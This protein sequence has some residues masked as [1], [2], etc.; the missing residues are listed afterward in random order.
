MKKLIYR[1]IISLILI[2]S[3]SII[4]LSTIGLKTERFNDLIVSKI[5]EVDPNLNLKINQVSVKL[6]L[7]SLVINLK[8]LGTDL[9]YKNRIIELEN[10]KSQI[11][12]K[13]VIK[14]RFALSEI[15][16]STKSIPI[17]NLISLIRSIKN[18]PKLLFAEKFIENGYIIAD[19]K[20]E[21]NKLGNIKKNFKINGLV[22]NA[23]LSLTKNKITKLNFIFQ[24]TD[25]E[26]NF[27]DVRLLLNNKSLSIPELRAKKQKNKFFFIGKL[28]NQNLNFKKDEISEIIDNKFLNSNFN[29]ITF[30]SNS[31][32]TFNIDEKFKIKDLDIKSLINVEK[33]EMN[34]FL[35]K[36]SFLP[37][38]KKEII[39]ENQKIKLSYYKN[40]IDIIGSGNLFLQDN[41][42]NINYEI[43]CNK[44][45]YLFNV[46]LKIN[47]NPFT[48]DFINFEKNIKNNLDFKIKGTFKK[49]TLRFDQITLS[50]NENILSVENL[51]L[52]N[53]FKIEEIKNIRL[54][55][56]DKAKQKNDL[57]FKKDKKKYIIIGDS[58]NADKLITD[59][60]KSKKNDKKNFL[61]KNLKLNIDIKKVFLDQNSTVNNLKGNISFV[62][63]EIIE[64]NLDSEFLNKKNMKFTIKKNNDEKITTLFSNEAKPLVDRYKFIKGFSEGVLDFYSVKK[65]N[66]TKSTIKIYD[67]KLKELP[68][69]TKVL[70]LASLQ[71]IADLLSGEGIRF[72]EFEMNFS[73]EKD[74]MTI[75]EI[76]AIGPAISV[77]V[78]GYIEK[79]NLISLRGTLVPATT[80]N[81]TISSIPL[82]GDILVGKKVGEGVFGV[83][84]K[85]KGPPGNLETTVNPIKTLTPRFITRTLEKIKKN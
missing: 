5:R 46:N 41:L 72:N 23:Q 9:I 78:E 54:S 7:L 8:T 38:I 65:N 10:I 50:E 39:F 6:N 34:N 59:L 63:N 57:E 33:L 47:D 3:F 73:N 31:E 51:S 30:N 71:G 68:A 61:S 64:L 32:F 15:M 74:L 52:S 53:D 13:S 19:L 22:N 25:K 27:E 83:S 18:D 12:L 58:F 36:N 84:F 67:F 37:K 70:T 77:L 48:I 45:N 85:I 56:E 43:I 26:L 2:V 81:K 80:I 29:N 14:N 82:I 28:K 76:Y 16:I 79:D 62:D 49:N 1:I 35:G 17:K 75:D 60:L 24:I 20:F 4:Y 66:E 69:L 11:L 55:Y 42:D 21:F 44:D 40:K